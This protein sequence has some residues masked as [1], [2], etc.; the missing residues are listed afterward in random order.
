MSERGGPPSYRLWIHDP[1]NTAS[2]NGQAL[3]LVGATQNITAI[4]G[5]NRFPG[6]ATLE[7]MPGPVAGPSAQL[8]QAGQSFWLTLVEWIQGLGSTPGA[9]PVDTIAAS[10][11]ITVTVQYSEAQAQHLDM[12]QA[13][14][15]HWDDVSAT[16]LALPTTLN[17][18][19]RTLTGLSPDVGQF[20]PQAPL[21]CQADTSEP[22]DDLYRASVL[23][24]G[25]ASTS[26]VFDSA[27]DEDWFVW[28]AQANVPYVI[29][30]QGLAAGVDTV[31]EMR[32]AG[33]QTVLASDDN[34]GGGAASRIERRFTDVG[35]Y[36]A[37]V[38]LKAGSA[39]GCASTYQLSVF[40]PR[41]L[42]PELS[43]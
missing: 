28:E 6:Q 19:T 14:I 25:S 35:T 42:L 9:L 22:D 18:Q 36:F 13:A 30:T 40:I 39:I 29:R 4:V 34:S 7:L 12:S 1:A 41:V 21:L 3:T 24:L 16:W 43:R 26:H 23:S 11:P 37:R 33:G 15:Y 32:D 5:A 38:A 27:A 10:D 8:R 20:S 31:L 2:T 17:A